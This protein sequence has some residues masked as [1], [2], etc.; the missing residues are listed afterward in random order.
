MAKGIC[1]L[2]C[3]RD[4]EGKPASVGK[5]ELLA[6]PGG[7]VDVGDGRT[8]CS[9]DGGSFRSL[10]QIPVPQGKVVEPEARGMAEDAD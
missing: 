8:S 5:N 7:T 3:S 1:E 4:G 2:L 6:E 9:L 10:F